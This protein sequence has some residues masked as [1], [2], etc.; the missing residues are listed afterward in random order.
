L[1][2]GVL[3]LPELTAENAYIFRITHNNNLP[4][5][6][7]KDFIVAIPISRTLRLNTKMWQSRL[8]L[9]S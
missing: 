3:P 9:R 4:W 7:D 8:A 1:R 5:I 2:R 6:L